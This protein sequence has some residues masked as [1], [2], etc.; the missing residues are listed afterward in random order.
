MREIIKPWSE[1][2]RPSGIPWDSILQA[3][4][5]WAYMLE[6]LLRGILIWEELPGIGLEQLSFLG[7]TATSPAPYKLCS[8]RQVFS[9]HEPSSPAM[10]LWW[11]NFEVFLFLSGILHQTPIILATKACWFTN[12]NYVGI[13]TLLF[14]SSLFEMSMLFWIFPEIVS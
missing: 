5:I 2:S 11:S 1:G 13:L 7:G 10:G 6:R 14:S 4:P 12:L 9:L 8:Q 3:S